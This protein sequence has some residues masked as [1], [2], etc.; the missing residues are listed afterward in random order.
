MIFTLLNSSFLGSIVFHLDVKLL[1]KS[2]VF[3]GFMGGDW[4]YRSDIV[5]QSIRVVSSASITFP[6]SAGSIAH[7]SNPTS[8]L[9]ILK[10]SISHVWSTESK[11]YLNI[12]PFPVSILCPRN[13][14][15]S[16]KVVSDFGIHDRRND[17][18]Y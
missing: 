11:A 14:V 15:G 4:R 10:I 17:F 18:V 7:L 6:F 1:L 16:S 8:I 9:Y 12:Y 2:Q 5:H 13:N 3:T